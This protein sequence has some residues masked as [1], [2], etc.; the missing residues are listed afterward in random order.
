VSLQ[1][2]LCKVK[3]KKITV[4]L[5]K[6]MKAWNREKDKN[7]RSWRMGKENIVYWGNAN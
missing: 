1:T 4:L 3:S 7:P 6:E 5:G 2:Q